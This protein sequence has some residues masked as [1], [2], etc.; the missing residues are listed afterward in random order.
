MEKQA[1]AFVKS[2]QRKTVKQFRAL[3]GYYA[4]Y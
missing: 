2:Q 3:Y 4:V 1:P